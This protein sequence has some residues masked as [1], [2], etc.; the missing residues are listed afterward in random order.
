MPSDP[1]ILGFDTSAAHCA[2]ALLS[3]EKIVSARHEEMAR[4]QAERLMPMIEEV[5]A[6]AGVTPRDLTAIGVGTGP[7]NFTGVRI[8]VS[9]ARAM[10]LALDIPAIGVSVFDAAAFGT[11]GPVLVA[12]AAPRGQAHLQR[13]GQ[14]DHA[15]E[16]LAIDE[17]PADYALRGSLCIGSAAAEVAARLGLKV[18]PAPYAPA[19]AVARVAASRLGKAQERPAPLYLRP[20]D[21][22]PPREAPPVILP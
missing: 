21:A 11:E 20:A 15:P 16:L 13:F 9:A 4:G 18:Q 1:L 6:E 8:A 2:A 22:A 14:D 3:G 12:H 10:A 7:G 5:L 19:A 17:I